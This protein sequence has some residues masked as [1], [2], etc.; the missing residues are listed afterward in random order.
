LTIKIKIAT[1][2]FHTITILAAI[3][4]S[5]HPWHL[6]LQHWI[7]YD[8]PHRNTICNHPAAWFGQGRL[9]FGEIAPFLPCE[10]FYTAAFHVRKPGRWDFSEGEFIFQSIPLPLFPVNHKLSFPIALRY[11]VG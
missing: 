11:V 2:Y 8:R 5:P 6:P 4:S 3:T 1:N 10:F 9:I 7:L